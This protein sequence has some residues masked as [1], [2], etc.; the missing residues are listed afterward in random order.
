MSRPDVEPTGSALVDYSLPADRDRGTLDAD[1]LP[2]DTAA[3]LDAVSQTRAPH[4]CGNLSDA[5]VRIDCLADALSALTK[6]GPVPPDLLSAFCTALAQEEQVRTLGT[7][8]DRLGRTG[9]TL[10]Y[11][12]PE[13]SVDVMIVD[14]TTRRLLDTELIDVD[15]QITD[16]AHRP[17]FGLRSSNQPDG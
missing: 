11:L 1:A 6:V 2:R 8:V 4:G 9:V 16:R 17:C 14:P 7:T 10:A 13:D 12:A 15:G 5:A 3:L